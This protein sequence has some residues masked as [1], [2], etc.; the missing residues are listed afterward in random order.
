M[1]NNKLFKMFSDVGFT[2]ENN[3]DPETELLVKKSSRR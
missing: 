2:K 1:K 3:K